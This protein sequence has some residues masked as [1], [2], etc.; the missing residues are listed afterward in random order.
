MERHNSGIKDADSIVKEILSMP[1][2]TSKGLDGVHKKIFT[3]IQKAGEGH[4]EV[5]C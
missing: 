3:E 5:S 4:Q 2:E 1:E